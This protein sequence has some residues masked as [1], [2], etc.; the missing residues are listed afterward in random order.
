MTAAVSI[1]PFSS[2][3]DLLTALRER[4]VSSV[5]LL[6]LYLARIARHNPAVN[7]VVEPDF[8]RAREAAVAAD[9]RRARGEDGALLGLPLTL[10]E[11]FN[12]AGLRTTCGAPE[13]KD[14]RVDFDAPI[15]RKVKAAGGVI[16]GKTNVPP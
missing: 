13:W 6:D 3:T 7:A 9:A 5:E 11:S 10:K 4:R 2:A 16:M 12:V 14:T 8:E 15:T 1:D